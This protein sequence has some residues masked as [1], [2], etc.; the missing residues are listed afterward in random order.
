MN[1]HI[2]REKIA[3]WLNLKD[4]HVNN[5]GTLIYRAYRKD[6][7]GPY[8]WKWRKV[9]NFADP[10]RGLC[11]LFDMI[12]IPVLWYCK[13]ELLEG[14]FFVWEVGAEDYSPT[15][16]PI[17]ESP[18]VALALAIEKMIDTGKTK[19]DVAVVQPLPLI[20]IPDYICGNCDQL[21]DNGSCLLLNLKKKKKDISCSSIY[22]YYKKD[23][24]DTYRECK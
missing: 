23:K 17:D 16:G 5:E 20:S 8:N 13:M 9:P 3:R 24:P 1:K 12:V 6:W 18:A 15:R 21:S 19:E 14:L 10:K 2:D 11:Y 7:V 4:V 22:R